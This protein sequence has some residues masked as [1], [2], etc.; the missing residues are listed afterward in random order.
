MKKMTITRKLGLIT[1]LTLLGSITIMFIIILGSDE[2]ELR[3]NEHMRV[4]ELAL[5][6][7]R[8]IEFAMGGGIPDIAPFLTVTKELPNLKEL[9]VIPTN[10]IRNG[11]ENDLEADEREVLRTRKEYFA[12]EQFRK[13]DVIRSISLITASESCLG[14]HQSELNAPL[15]TVSIRYSIESMNANIASTRLR[16]FIMGL[17]TI[18][19]TVGIITY[20]MR[21]RVFRDLKAVVHKIITLSTGT[22]T[23]PLTIDRTD[24]I[25]ELVSAYNELSKGLAN[26]TKSAT[27]IANGRLDREVQLLS[28]DDALGQ[29]LALVRKNIQ[30]LIADIC[31][32]NEKAL[33]GEL[34]TRIDSTLHSGEYQKIVVGINAMIE[35]ALHPVEEG[36]EALAVMANGD[37]TRE[38]QGN[39]QGDHK[40]IQDSINNLR[41]SLS[42]LIISIHESVTTTAGAVD[43]ISKSAE[44]IA[45]GA[46]EQSMHTGEVA[47]AI[48]E[49]TKTIF[50]T[51]QNASM[52]AEL[53]SAS[54]DKAKR[55]GEIVKATVTEMN[56]V[57]S[58]VSKSS[59][60]ISVLGQSSDRI[61]EIV[62]V[63]DEIADQ[64]NLLA[65]NAAIEAARAGEM[66]RG[67]AVVADEV[68]KLAERTSNATKEIAEMIRRIQHDTKEAVDTIKSGEAEVESGRKLATQAGKALEEIVAESQRVADIVV[69]VAAAS[70]EQS[71]TAEEISKSIESISAVSQD[72]TENVQQMAQSADNLS[73]L[74]EHLS[75][76]VNKFKINHQ[77]QVNRSKYLQK[78]NR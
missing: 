46:Q 28:D 63:I 18:I 69:Q 21:R 29:A 68:R 56:K 3:S 65:L 54:R 7:T 16:A 70:E 53:A 37:F 59:E 67:F 30:H 74:T 25:G 58:V 38:L 23:P 22:L 13:E 31:E 75:L 5:T 11:S 12:E 33:A 45:A 57:A 43:Q 62:T 72:A 40:I 73:S 39:Y 14:C 50:E 44:S 64:T 4:K 27:D 41:E 15:A 77:H 20:S 24:E 19:L 36:E 6:L 35:S 8:S 2:K 32:M 9:R 61:G 17:I 1:G 26:L 55:G 71:A 66:G 60:T 42:A 51:T 52:A 76:Q 34:K 48:E 47:S 10:V 78:M 49:M